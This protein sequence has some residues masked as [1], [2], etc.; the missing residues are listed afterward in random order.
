MIATNSRLLA[1]GVAFLFAGSNIAITFNSL[2]FAEQ[3]ASANIPA[4]TCSVFVLTGKLT[5]AD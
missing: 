4:S 3:L 2:H 1:E 5:C